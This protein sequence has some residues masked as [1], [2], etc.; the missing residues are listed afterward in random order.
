MKALA[1]I[2]REQLQEETFI[3][4]HEAEILQHYIRKAGLGG[5]KAPQPARLDDG[6]ARIIEEAKLLVDL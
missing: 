2:I 3:R 1:E 4:S 5:R 6:A